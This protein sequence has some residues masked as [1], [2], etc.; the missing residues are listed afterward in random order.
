MINKRKFNLNRKLKWSDFYE[1]NLK[2]YT[3]DPR[4]EKILNLK[5]Q[6]IMY[7]WDDLL[8]IFI[9]ADKKIRRKVDLIL[10]GHTHTLKEFRLKETQET[11]RINMGFYIAPIYIEIPCHV[12]TNRYRDK[13]EQF[14]DDL[15]RKVWFDVNKPFIFQTQAIGPISMNYK[16]KPPGFRFLKVR[17][18]QLVK[19][20]VF[21]LHLEDS[22]LESEKQALKNLGLD[23]NRI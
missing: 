8:K 17:N 11:E 2:E 12:Y 7:N 3:G 9:G 21:S 4:L 1:H 22:I 13:F 15:E 20:Q 18:Y 19:N 6:T 5:Y 23:P 10:C 16:F 14:E